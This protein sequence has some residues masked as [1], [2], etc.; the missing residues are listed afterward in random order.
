LHVIHELAGKQSLMYPNLFYVF[1]DWFGV[2]WKA[3]A[4]LNT[5]G[6]MVALAFI[7]A[8]WVITIELKRKEKQGL[9]LPREESITVGLPASLMDIFLN[10]VV[11]F[12]FGYKLIGLLFSK[13]EQM[14]AQEY[15]F[16]SMGNAAGGILFALVMGGFKWYDKYK[17]KLKEPEK[18]IVRIWPHDRVGDIVILG[19]VFGII[20]AKL[21][22]NFEHWDEFIADPIGRL[23]SQS[24]LAF[25]GGLI[26]ASIAICW[27]AYKKGIKVKHLTDA[28]APALMIAYAI[29]RIGCQVSG[30]GDWGVYNSAYVSDNQGKVRLAQP[31]EF[32]KA[33]E[34]NA[35]YFLEGKVT[36]SGRS[37]FVSDRT[38]ANL[39]Q[40]PHRSVKG[41]SFLPDWLFAYSYPQNVNKDGILMP[42][43]RDEHNRV[44][45]QPVFP[46]P[47]YETIIC[48]L[49][50]LLMWTM[51]RS[52]KTPLVMFGLYLFLNGAERYLIERIRVNIGYN[53]SGLRTTQ[54]ELIAIILAITG[55]ILM[56]AAKKWLSEKK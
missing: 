39:A 7:A 19:L 48:S 37:V 16:S 40:V 36:D 28:A 1:K 21:F 15:I 5:F 46:T 43:I 45:P 53:Y 42:G 55:V 20:G 50:F 31:G 44:L 35:S 29:G 26:L 54:A 8:A 6:L 52:I 25:Y 3:L 33:L 17:Q 32:E 10:A 22:D 13:P 41:P 51:R 14:N 56:I 11:G 24:G 9:M 30:D 12:V 18:R 4:F 2:E 34:K 27:Y 47:L 49:L 38:Y 23:F